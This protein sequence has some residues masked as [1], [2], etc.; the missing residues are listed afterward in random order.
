MSWTFVLACP[1][2]FQL[3][4]GATADGVRAAVFVLVGVTACVLVGCGVFVARLLRR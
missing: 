4:P 3:E 2:C 1:I